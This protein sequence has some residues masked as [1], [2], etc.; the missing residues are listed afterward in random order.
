[1]AR[2]IKNGQIPIDETML[3]D[4]LYSETDIFLSWINND[5]KHRFIH[6]FTDHGGTLQESKH[7]VNL[8]SK[9]KTGYLE[10]EEA[11][12]TSQQVRSNPIIFI[13]SLKQHNDIVNP[14]NFKLMLENEP[15]LKLVN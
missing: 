7:M 15:F 8:L 2:I 14:E 13:H 5:S 9:N 3:F 1:M 4:A 12:L 10:V 6:L 11:S